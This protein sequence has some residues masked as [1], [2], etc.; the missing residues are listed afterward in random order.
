MPVQRARSID[1]LFEAV[2]GYD[3]VLTVDAPLSLALNRRLDHPRLGRF[4]ATPQMLAADEFRPQDQR[5][6]FL[7][8]I[9][10]TALPW[11]QAAHLVEL[12]LGCWEE[13]GDRQAILEFERYD[14][15]K[16]REV[17]EVIASVESAHRDLEEYRID[18]DREV[19][20]IGESQFSAL[21]RSILPAEYDV[22]DPLT[23]EAFD[24][25]A[26]HSFASRTAI[27]EAIV[28]NVTSD[29]AD[30]VAIVMD[31]GGPF[32]ALIES[33]L[34]ARDIPF[35]GGPGFADDEGLRTFLE[36]L[37][38]AHADSRARVGDVRPIARGLGIDLPVDDEDKLL[39][40]LES[41]AAEPMQAFCANVPEWTFGEAIRE[42][43]EL[44]DRSLNVVRDELDVLGLVDKT[45]TDGRLDDLE[46]YFSAFDVPIDR[47]DSG[48]LLADANTS[49]YVDRPAVFYLGLDADWTHQVI[50]RPW[51]DTERKDR[52]HLRQFQLLLQNGREQYYLVQETSAGEPVRPCLYFHDLLDD[53]IET[54]D[55]FE[56]IPHTYRRGDGSTGFEHDPVS[57]APE[58]IET[59]SQS[60]LSTF[61]NCP[62][63]Y[64]F[65][66][67]VEQPDRDY[68]RKGNCYHDFAEFYVNH[69]DVVADA[70]RAELV[71]LFLDE[72]RPFVDQV[73]RDVLETEFDVGLD[74][75][76]RFIDENPPV[77]RD[78]SEYEVLPFGNLVANYFDHPIDSPITE[79]WFENPELGGRGKVDLI[80]SP[81]Q[82]LDYKS[83]SA[84]SAS[85]VVDRSSIEEIHDKPDFQA[86]LY[87]AHHR[88]VRPD[89]PI[90]FVFYHFLDLVDDAIT[91]TADVEDA[92]VRVTYYPVAFDEWVGS[93]TAFD[94]LCEGVAESND[95]RKTLEK[96]GYDAYAQF[97]G[98]HTFP[99]VDEKE[100]LLDTEFADAFVRYARDRV[101]EYKY[102]TSGIES[103]LKTLL[104][105]RGENYFRDDVEAFEAFLDE[106]IALIN[107][108]R[109]SSFP[110]GDP[111]L[112]RVTH[113][114]LLLTEGGGF[115][116]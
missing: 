105:L 61:V 57:A 30:D 3:L 37:R 25:P 46:F 55:D 110:V 13:T 51:I 2:A 112:D 52:E 60:S 75:I 85:Q 16:T 12:I 48:V 53:D 100:I 28:D 88:R 5:Q 91:G 7:D 49:T 59:I 97:L 104:D 73:D 10:S 81:T 40:E 58:S 74:L 66:Q 87:L 41:A 50:D 26:F 80:H 24:L 94:A 99:D 79:Q 70:D 98:S 84:K 115:D 78:Y 76:E 114:D 9:E 4:A 90:D 1:D 29:N 32:P 106:Q 108:Y 102:V 93:Q 11:K 82:L 20:V 67:V 64:F 71:D 54:F 43:E 72:L 36:L 39:G 101:G 34:E 92:L 116:D 77:E 6:L 31:R 62:R 44:S 111:N 56:T 17:L 63:D 65:D 83:G 42:F 8:V 86:M 23:S 96:L 113:R 45:V 47:E 89:E 109:E 14:T 21:D 95:R 15:P 27:V 68:F 107:E 38:L 22:I 33:A 19:A 103:A 35:H 69:P 18:D